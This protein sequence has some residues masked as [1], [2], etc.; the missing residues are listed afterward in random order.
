MTLSHKTVHQVTK[1]TKCVDYIHLMTM[2]D[3][4]KSTIFIPTGTTF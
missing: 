2:T 3:Y 1:R 4:I